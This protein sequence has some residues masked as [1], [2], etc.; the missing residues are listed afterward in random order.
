MFFCFESA[1]ELWP[2]HHDMAGYFRQASARVC[3]F[4]FAAS[5]TDTPSKYFIPKAMDSAAALNRL[6]AVLTERGIGLG[7]DELGWLFESPQYKDSMTS[8]V[9]EYLSPATL[10]SLE[11]HDLYV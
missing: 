10:L 8:W 5:Y 7:Y 2:W 11:E 3:C 6:L 4:P 9:H 1:Q